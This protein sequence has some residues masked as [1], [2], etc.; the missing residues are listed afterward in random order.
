MDIEAFREY[1]LGV[2]GAEECLPF[3]DITLVYKAMGKMFAYA[4]L[5]PRDGLF[6]ANMK[7]DPDKSAELMERYDGIFFG[8]HS[9]KK[10]WITV[11][12]ESDVPD[13]LIRELLDH[14]VV[15]VIRKL[16]K[17]KQAQYKG[18]DDFQKK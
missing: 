10:Y 11:R 12:L 3:D 4:P 14:S 18:I 1:C 7:C 8:P 5:G 16:P 6:W 2:K 15:E 9:D 17:Y 13:S